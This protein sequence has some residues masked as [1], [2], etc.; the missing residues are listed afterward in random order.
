MEDFND[1][2][3]RQG[4]P[5]MAEWFRNKMDKAK[6]GWTVGMGTRGYSVLKILRQ[7]LFDHEW[8]KLAETEKSDEMARAIAD[9]VNHMTGV[10]KTG[11]HPAARYALFA[12]K[13]LLSRLSVVGG[14]PLR[15]ANSLLHA[16]NMTPAEK[17]FAANQFKEK[18][19]MLA[20]WTSLLY[21]NQQLINLF[22]GNQ[23]VNV[24]DP[25]KSDFMKF[26]IAGMNFAW[27]GPFLTMMRLPLRLIR[28]GMGNGGKTKNLIYPDETMVKTAFDYVRSQAS[29]IAGT[30]MDLIFKADYQER[31][32]PQIPGYGPPPPMP[33]RLK[34]QGMK[35]YT[36]P[37]FVSTTLLPIPFEEAAHEVFHYGVGESPEQEKALYKSLLTIL[38]MGGTG[39]RLTDDWTKKSV[40]SE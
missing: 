30:A 9:S 34:A 20:V 24:T 35:P 31:P 22:G 36:W 3:L 39:G 40:M 21:A 32:L 37:E 16:K 27:G 12:P 38:I 23:Q 6:L 29:P 1:P 33:K 5:K 11:S 26:K 2:Q 25:M 13:L 14:D 8:N 15:A 28:I 4:F 10:V 17:W 19:K 7:D 18:A